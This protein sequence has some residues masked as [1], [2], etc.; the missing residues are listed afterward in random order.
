MI[1]Q[2]D[3]QALLSYEEANYAKESLAKSRRTEGSF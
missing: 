1:A 2:S 3:Q